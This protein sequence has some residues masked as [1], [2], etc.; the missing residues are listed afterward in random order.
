MTGGIKLS[1]LGRW[2][3]GFGGRDVQG[4]RMVWRLPNSNI[5][6]ECFLVVV[7]EGASVFV[8]RCLVVAVRVGVAVDVEERRTG[9]LSDGK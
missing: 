7:G 5:G 3:D 1:V 9:Q 2:S 8:R 4:C 6:W